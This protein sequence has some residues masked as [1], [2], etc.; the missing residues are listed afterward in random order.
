MQEPFSVLFSLAN[1]WAHWWGMAQLKTHI[2]PSYPL[3]RYMKTFG[4]LGYAAWV[5]S[6]VFHARDTLVTERLDYL[7]AGAYVLY[8][9]FFAPIRILRWHGAQDG[10]PE[11]GGR[12]QSQKAGLVRLWSLFCLGLYGA[13]IFYLLV[14][15]WNYTYN[16]AA[17]VV[18]GLLHSVCW[19]AFSVYESRKRGY[20]WQAWPGCIVAMIVSVMGLELLDFPPWGR[21]VDAHS[22]WHLGTVVP[23]LWWYKYVEALPFNEQ[24]NVWI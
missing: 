17:N 7:G 9:L 2:P 20:G 11:K 21:M 22:L 8:G 15:R 3:L 14:I 13:H 10:V 6:A 24:T 5:F 19:T 16:M 12:S 23:T 4:Y 1:F 18:V